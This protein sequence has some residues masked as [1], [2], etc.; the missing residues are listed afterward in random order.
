MMS[1]IK[2]QIW[3]RVYRVRAPSL[4]LRL[5]ELPRAIVAMRKCKTSLVPGSTYLRLIS[6]S[7]ALNR[8][9]MQ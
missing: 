3:R 1:S 8:K 9:R 2:F 4:G 5:S 7:E 6:F